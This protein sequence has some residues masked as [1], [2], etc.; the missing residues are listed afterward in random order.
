MFSLD[1]MGNPGNLLAVTG[2]GPDG[3]G[4][5][6]APEQI[7]VS[8]MGGGMADPLAGGM[9]GMQGMG[10]PMAQPQVIVIPPGGTELVDPLAIVNE[11]RRKRVA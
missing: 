6:T 3:I 5:M 8:P 9:Q 7:T 1:Q 10:A 4:G 2:E 11:I